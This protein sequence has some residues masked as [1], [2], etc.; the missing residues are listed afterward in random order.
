M[1]D[2]NDINKVRR[3]RVG[4]T[5]SDRPGQT[6]SSRDQVNKEVRIKKQAGSGDN[7]YEESSKLVDFNSR[8]K[9]TSDTY[10]EGRDR[11]A[12]SR[13]RSSYDEGYY[14]D[15]DYYDDDYDYEEGGPS[16]LRR[17][18]KR[19]ILVVLVI[20]I[21]GGSAGFLYVRSVVSDMP[22]LTKKMV[23]ESYINKEPVALSRIPAN[24]QK[25]VIAIED[26]RFYD[27]KGVDYRSFVR[28]ILNNLTGGS[29]QG[30]STI[31][32]QV[33]KNLLTSNEKTIKRKIQ[34]MHNAREL[35]KIMTKDE[36]LEAYLNNI[37]L[38]KSAY[39]VQAGAHLYFGKDVSNLTFGE[40]TMLAGITNNPSLYQ[41]YEQAKKRQ[42]AVLYRMY[43]LGYIKEN[44]YKA[45]MYRDTPFKSEIDQ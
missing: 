36:I 6:R 39:G 4:S 11:D 5:S 44:V 37:Y 18:L 15:N 1:A 17:V 9:R 23:N 7:Y 26:H 16:R 20:S 33:S 2:N 31:D 41:N 40:C 14:D 35:N 45:Q 30:A 25:A 34:D 24:L 10:T 28:S 22:V 29:T 3:K 13:R 43:K 38:G 8:R 32:M 42:A 27:H 12:Y 21:V 19:L